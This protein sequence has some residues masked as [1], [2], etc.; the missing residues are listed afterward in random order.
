VNLCQQ[1]RAAIQ[2]LEKETQRTYLT[3]VE[4]TYRTLADILA[5]AGRLG[6]A[7][8]VLGLLKEEE[9][10]EFVRRDAAT[11]KQL[12]G[13][14]DLTSADK[15]ALGR[16][17]EVAD[18]VTALGGRVEDLRV[19]RAR[20]AEQE[21][22]LTNLTAD[23]TAAS[24]AF[25]VVL[26]QIE[27]EMGQTPEARDVVRELAATRGLGVDLKSLGEAVAVISTVV[28]DK[29]VW[30]ILTTPT[31]QV[32]GKS[33]ILAADLNRRVLALREALQDPRVDPRPLARELYS[34]LIGPVEK[35]LAG[36]APK[37]LAWSLDGTLRYLPVAALYDGK[38]YLVERYATAVLTLAGR[39]RLAL[40]PT[41]ARRALGVGVSQPHEGFRG[42]PSVP[43]ELQAVIHEEAIEPPGK[44]VLPGHVL[45]NEAFTR[46][47]LEAGL[48]Q[49][50]PVVHVASHF[51]FQPGNATDS[52]L[53]LGD[54]G[55]LTLE[56]M[57]SSGL[58][59]FGG[60]ELLTLSACD[61]AMGGERADGREV[62]GFGV[63]AQNQGA[64]AVIATLWP[65]ADESTAEVMAGFYRRRQE[66]G[67]SKGEAL[68]EAQLALLQGR[69]EFT[70]ER[71]T[72]AAQ[73][74][75]S[76]EALAVEGRDLAKAGAPHFAVDSTRPYAHPYYWAP[77]ILMGNWR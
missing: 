43:A 72:A 18:K 38:R 22:E 24:K 31:I 40:E 41:A 9:Y 30:V 45:L 47:A 33:K 60:V 64:R 34:I 28:T 23:L 58:P 17:E 36:A 76:P 27:D 3:T 49:G 16:Y 57:R 62:E 73:A 4:G 77:F 15:S 52:F 59:M 70:G 1:L 13:R 75:R 11:A 53:L 74:T 5:A 66:K 39:S 46:Q 21:A 7:Q 10:F 14:A 8:Q 63:E 65:V 71:A 68:R 67:L 6:E 25:Q 56:D 69:V 12:Q 48:Q 54:G 26:R 51:A 55:H 20:T 50:Y 37:T 35:D 29:A 61:T 42:L 32:A 2:T 44:G 19:I